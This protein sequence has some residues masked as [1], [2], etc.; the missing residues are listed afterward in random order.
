MYS[1][2]TEK[3]GFSLFLMTLKIKLFSL[4]LYFGED[5]IWHWKTQTH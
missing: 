5:S 2:A 3:L 1:L 4:G